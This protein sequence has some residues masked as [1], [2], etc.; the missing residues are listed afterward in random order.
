MNVRTQQLN[1]IFFKMSGTGK[2]AQ[3]DCLDCGIHFN[4]LHI[5]HCMKFGSF[6]QK[7]TF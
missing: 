4:L 2:S 3:N 1:D 5:I 7:L 6:A